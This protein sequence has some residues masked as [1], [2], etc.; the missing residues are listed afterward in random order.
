MLKAVL[1]VIVAGLI[2]LTACSSSN[3]SVNVVPDLS[4]DALYTTAKAQMASGDYSGAQRYLE[5]I[6]SRYPFGELTDQIQLDLIYVYYKSRNS[7]MTSAAISRYLRLNPTSQYTDY[8]MYMQGLNQIQMRSDMVQDFIGLD[9]SQKDPTNYYE[10]IK[11][12]KNLIATYPQSAYVK[13]AY[14]RILY[15]KQQLAEREFHIATYY[16][17]RQA[18]LSC[19]RRCQSILYSYRDT[20]QLKPALEMMTTCYQKL[21]LNNAADNTQKVINASAL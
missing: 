14:Q 8:V 3:E 1:P 11:T 10:A 20:E 12:F 19:I 2:S 4:A 13:D 6:D 9:R 16:F 18:Y 7:E 21:G 5:A 17:E 15:I